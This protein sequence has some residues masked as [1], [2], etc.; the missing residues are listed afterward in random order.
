VASVVCS[1]VC[2]V[3]CSVVCSVV[4]WGGCAALAPP[5]P[6]PQPVLAR[7]EEGLAFAN[8]LELSEEQIPPMME[9]V[10]K[11]ERAVEP[12][13]WATED[14]LQALAATVRRCRNDST[15]LQMRA[16]SLVAAGEAARRPLLRAINELHGLL[17]P[18][19][20]RALARHLLDEERDSTPE[21]REDRS[22]DEAQSASLQLDLSL[23]QL[24]LMLL[25]LHRVQGIYEDKAEPWL[26][27][28]RSTVRAFVRA[29]FDIRDHELAEVPI[30]ELATGFVRDAFRLLVPL[31]EPDQ[32]LV[33][34]EYLEALVDE[35]EKKRAASAP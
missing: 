31:L 33:V 3:V 14:L 18:Q 13:R 5:E 9:L 23:V 16:E 6:P 1:V 8:W 32:C 4:C 19:Q 15:Y 27:R 17:T 25:H 24:G 10:E 29:D 22:T 21:A 20:R 28:Y 30:F 35:A 34:S 2:W 7:T 12:M 11:V 26:E